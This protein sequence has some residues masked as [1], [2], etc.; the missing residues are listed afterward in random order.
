MFKTVWNKIKEVLNALVNR[1]KQ[2]CPIEFV[3]DVKK[4]WQ[5]A[6]IQLAGIMVFADVLYQYIPFIHQYVSEGVGSTIGGLLIVLRVLQLKE[7][8]RN[9]RS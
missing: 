2:I 7:A 6:S 3:E 1:V 4:A 5:W 9:N 8:P